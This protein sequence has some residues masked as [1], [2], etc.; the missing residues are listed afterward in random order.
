MIR[1]LLAFAV[2]AALAVSTQAF[3]VPSIGQPALATPTT[4]LDA[5]RVNAK[6]EKRKRNRDNM[7]KF[8]KGGRRGTSRKK[9]M[10][11]LQSSAARQ[12]E[13]EFIAKCFITVPPPNSEEKA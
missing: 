9:M 2:L 3:V 1:S 7:R 12:I 6:Q 4:S 5:S 10:R 13:N 8:K 11:K